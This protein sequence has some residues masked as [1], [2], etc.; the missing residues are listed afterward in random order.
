MKSERA[1]LIA[2]VIHRLD[3]GGL[4]NGLVNLVN[5]IPAERYR[6]AIVCLSGYTDFGKRIRASGVQIYSVDKR[7]GKDPRAYFRL[8]KMLRRLGPTIVHTRNLGT[9]DVQ[10][11]VLAAGLH[12]RVHGEHGWDAS[13]PVGQGTRSVMI[14]R[15]CRP[16]IQRYVALSDD[17]ARWLETTIR[18][19]PG[20]IRRICNGVDT[21]KFHPEGALPQ[22]LPWPNGG[23]DQPVVIGTV[24]R[25]DPVKNLRMLLESFAA[26]IVDHPRTARPLR[27]IVV[28]DGPL[29]KQLELRADEMGIRTM[30]WFTGQRDDVPELLRAMDIF[31]LPSLNEGISNTLLEAMACGRP[32]IASRVGGN[33]ELVVDGQCGLLFDGTSAASLTT[34]LL[35]YVANPG[36]RREHGAAARA[37]ARREFSLAAMV[38]GYLQLYD[39]MMAS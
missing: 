31:V 32:V 5:S 21:D 22:D 33:P 6:Q 13:D 7:P 25:L 26:A 17:L 27:L 12:R 38:R 20:K 11:I 18:V 9:V 36:R 30:V 37:R 14:R 29:R 39:E 4:E 35:H 1:P 2:H 8:W 15:M 28:G 10:W 34:T 16:V 24:A 23:Q 3:Y 19:D